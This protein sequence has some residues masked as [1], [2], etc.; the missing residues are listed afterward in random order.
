MAQ[1]LPLGYA[2]STCC[3]Q[4]IP[5]AGRPMARGGRLGTLTSRPGALVMSPL[6]YDP[7][8]PALTWQSSRVLG[9]RTPL[10]ASA[11]LF[12]LPK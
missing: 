10:V 4:A 11:P 3:C 5:V 8:V 9:W 1:A 6:L 7:T 12:D 2:R